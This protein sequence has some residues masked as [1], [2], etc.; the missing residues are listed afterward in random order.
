MWKCGNVEMWKCGNARPKRSSRRMDMRLL[1]YRTQI[2]M[3]IMISHDLSWS[4][5]RLGWEVAVGTAGQTA[6]LMK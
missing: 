6:I 5:Q 3:I 2:F 1:R 4:C